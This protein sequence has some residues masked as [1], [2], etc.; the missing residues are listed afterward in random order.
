MAFAES[1]L[2]VSQDEIDD[3]KDALANTGQANVFVNTMAERETQVRDWTAAYVV[4]EETLK[5]LWRPLVLFHLYGLCGPVP[6]YR[7][8][9]YDEAIKELAAIRDGK[10][11]QYDLADE[12]P[13]QLASGTAAWGSQ[14]RIAGRME[15]SDT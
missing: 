4:P 14:T 5:R 3:L 8:K 12:Q 7:Q 9:A 2:N 13:G 11:P 10:F 1:D 6:D 15:S